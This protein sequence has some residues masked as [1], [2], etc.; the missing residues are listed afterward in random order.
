MLKLIQNSA[1]GKSP[2]WSDSYNVNKEIYK[3]SMTANG[4]A[5][6]SNL[7]SKAV[8]EREILKQV[9]FPKIKRYQK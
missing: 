5:N 9:S 8:M 4:F 6:E 2:K 1:I 3:M 7:N